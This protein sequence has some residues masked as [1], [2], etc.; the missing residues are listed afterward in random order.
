MSLTK[1]K[2]LAD[3]GQ[4]AEWRRRGSQELVARQEGTRLLIATDASKAELAEIKGD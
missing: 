1:R 4:Y 2:W 3:G